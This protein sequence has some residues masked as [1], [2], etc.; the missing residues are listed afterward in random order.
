MR[1]L[2]PLLLLLTPAVPAQD[3]RIEDLAARIEALTAELSLL[4][5]DDENERRRA[6]EGDA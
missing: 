2:L 3:E 4:E 6:A 1:L 5:R